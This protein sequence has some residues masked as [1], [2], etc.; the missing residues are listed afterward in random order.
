MPNLN[1]LQ[2]QILNLEAGDRECL[3]EWLLE[4]AGHNLGLRR[5]SLPPGIEKQPGVCG[6]D[7]RIVRT[8]IPVWLIEQMRRLGSSE[9]EILRCYPTLRAE[10]LVHAWWYVDLHES[11]ITQQIRDNEQ[12]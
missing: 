12:A 3:T 6:G 4:I 10:D 9:A 11:E 7:P 8:R 2:E 1:E 5:V